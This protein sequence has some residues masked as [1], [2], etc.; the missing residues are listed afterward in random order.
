VDIAVAP[1]VCFEQSSH[2]RRGVLEYLELHKLHFPEQSLES[3][4]HY[5]IHYA[6]FIE[7]IGPLLRDS[8][9]RFESKH[10]RSKKLLHVSGNYKNVPKSCA[11]WTPA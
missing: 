6:N 2:L 10:Q 9:M 5:L 4:R 7:K 8:C 3:K 11:F 1:S